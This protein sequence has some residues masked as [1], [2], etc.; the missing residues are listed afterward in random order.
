MLR[1]QFFFAVIT[2]LGFQAAHADP[3]YRLVEQ[4]EAGYQNELIAQNE[5]NDELLSDDESFVAY[6]DDFDERS[7]EMLPWGMN[8]NEDL[9]SFIEEHAKEAYRDYEEEFAYDDEN[10]DFDRPYRSPSLEKVPSRSSKQ[11]G[12]VAEAP[13]KS[14]KQVASKQQRAPSKKASVKNKKNV[15][16]QSERSSVKRKVAT[17]PK[18]K[19]QRSQKSKSQ[20]AVKEQRAKVA[21]KREVAQQKRRVMKNKENV[22]QNSI[23]KKPREKIVYDEE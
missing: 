7:E 6:E 22:S 2:L 23:R 1:S 10:E 21:K 14:S 4:E 20:V 15:A 19:Q 9:T 16:K 18:A 13:K 8:T 17:A 3:L 5:L 11:Q 12:K